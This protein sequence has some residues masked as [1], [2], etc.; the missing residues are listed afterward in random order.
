MHSSKNNKAV[1]D[2]T[3]TPVVSTSTVTFKNT[4]EIIVYTRGKYES[5]E[6]RRYGNPTTRAVEDALLSASGMNA[7]TTMLL[8][9]VLP[10]G[11]VVLSTD[12]YRRTRQFSQTVLPNLHMRTT[13]IDR[14]DIDGLRDALHGPD[15]AT[16]VFSEVPRLYASLA[17]PRLP[18]CVANM[19]PSP[20]ATPHLHRSTITAPALT[21]PTSC[22][23]LPPII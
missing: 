18:Y 5:F 11:H 13:V 20:L 1:P 22:C 6:Y 23:T 7:I 10:G 12:C 2:A 21:A 8:A 9:L 19:A 3:T 16:S 14:A 15:G 17:R 4:A